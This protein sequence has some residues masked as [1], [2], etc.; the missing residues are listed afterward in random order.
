MSRLNIAIETDFIG[1]QYLPGG[2][3][4]FASPNQVGLLSSIAL[5]PE[6]IANFNVGLMGAAQVIQQQQAGYNAP[7]IVDK[8]N[9]LL[10]IPNNVKVIATSGGSV[11]FKALAAL[12]AQLVPPFVS[13]VG[14]V[15]NG[16]LGNCKG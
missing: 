7:A 13:L 9:Q 6:M 3:T 1:P 5:T 14:S 4:I 10:Q 8:K 16:Q 12:P 15:P 11:V 2:P